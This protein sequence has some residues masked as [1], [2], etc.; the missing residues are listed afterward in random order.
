MRLILV[1]LLCALVPTIAFAEEKKPDAPKPDA[2]PETKPDASKTTAAKKPAPAKKATPKGLLPDAWMSKMEW[3]AIGP[4]NMGGRVGATIAHR[5]SAAEGAPR[6]P[7]VTYH[8]PA[9][10]VLLPGGRPMPR[11]ATLARL[12]CAAS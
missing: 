8:P 10:T 4:A 12:V 11:T 5:T 6:R 9:S 1:A 2:R 3:R 7:R